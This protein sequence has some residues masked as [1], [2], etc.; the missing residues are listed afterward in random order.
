MIRREDMHTVR[1]SVKSYEQLRA[2]LAKARRRITEL[3]RVKSQHA[4]MERSLREREE[5]YRKIIEHSNDAIYL[6]DPVQNRILDANSTACRMLGYTRAE[7]L[8]IGVSAIHPTEMDRLRAFAD[9]VF[10]NGRGWTDELTC[11][12]KSG[13][14]LPAEISASVVDID[15][16]P[17]M[18]AVV[19]NTTERK[20]AEE[21]IRREVARADALARTAGRLNAQ[22]DLDA[23]L[24]AIC[25]ET[26]RALDVSAAAV[27]FYDEQRSLFYPEV[28]C[29]LPP[30]F[31]QEYVPNSRSV[32]DQ[33]PQE[34]GPQIV[35][36]N[37]QKLSNLPN[38]E[39]F[40]RHGIHAIA[41]ASLNRKNRLM[42]ALSAYA[43][44]PTRT[45]SEEDIML[46]RGLADQ[47]A[48]A[49]RNAHLFRAE[50]RRSEQFRVISEVGQFITSILDVDELLEQIVKAVRN[51]FKY[52]FVGVALV[53]GDEVVYKAG[54]G[55]FLQDTGQEAAPL[56]RFKVG[57]E[58]LSGWVAATGK[59]LVVPDVRRDARYRFVANHAI[60]S[61]MTVPIKVQN[62]VIG[63][64][65]I[66]SEQLDAFDDDD[67]MVV[68]CLADQAA[69]AIENA[70]L[71][72]QTHHLAVLEE[73]QRLARELHDSV[74]QALYGMTLYTEAA[75]D[76]L[77]MGDAD[78]AAEYLREMR[79]TSQAA[80]REMRLLI[81]QLRPVALEEG[82][83][84]AIQE[85]L[86]TVEQRSGIATQLTV[87]GTPASQGE[88]DK[89]V[90][91]IAQ[92][93]LNNALKHA[94]AEHVT[95][96]LAWND[97]MLILEIR[98]DG[99]GFD[100]QTVKDKGGLG[101]RGMHERVAKLGGQFALNSQPGAGTR[102]YVEVPLS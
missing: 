31:K 77:A 41:I 65:N 95:V 66:E 89:E 30:S 56:P 73:R 74:T 83:V 19:R 97:A 68:Q 93:A 94:A 96:H 46:L 59:P 62:R 5:R 90:Y 53:E 75:T 7:L 45:F 91:R 102:I 60:R 40:A 43:R 78:T 61:E 81:Y 48:Q 49:I 84:A 17:R 42:G 101:L 12:T 99:A 38:A 24:Q 80:L 20:A 14:F 33:W 15:G 6:I 51:F 11:R 88:L 8:S 22:L 35:V 63:V 21:R 1:D 29:G 76:L 70:R 18:I 79:V 86:E 37:L 58:G 54:I 16:E 3:E 27:L 10:A 9:S 28:T 72:A 55:Y 36:P 50:Q 23:V 100:P 25:E 85:R 52:H 69:V 92:E 4:R 57:Q 44:E 87:E 64:L 2:E 39:L 13:I 82:L 34:D 32:Y 98:D 71:Y 26:M 67:L 47:A